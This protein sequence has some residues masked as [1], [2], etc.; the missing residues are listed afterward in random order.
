MVLGSFFGDGFIVVNWIHWITLSLAI[1][2][3]EILPAMK[4]MD[5]PWWKHGSPLGKW[6]MN[7]FPSYHPFIG[8][9]FPLRNKPCYWD[10]PI[11]YGNPIDS[12]EISGFETWI[13]FSMSYVDVILPIDEV[14][15]FKMVIA[16]PTR[17]RGFAHLKWFWKIH[18]LIEISGYLAPWLFT[19]LFI[20]SWKI[21]YWFPHPFIDG[22][23]MK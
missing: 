17:I 22:L 9:D 3:N 5:L 18:L 1:W 10:F 19:H 20:S 16:P 11:I 15:F 8:W 7:W 21:H 14:I 13:L 23:S 2:P 6:Y 12:I 4:V